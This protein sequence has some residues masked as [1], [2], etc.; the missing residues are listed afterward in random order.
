[1]TLDFGD[2]EEEYLTILTPKAEEISHL[3][4]GYIDIILKA[5]KGERDK[6]QLERSLV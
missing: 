5:R 2:Y 6:N 1:M 4:A 3:I